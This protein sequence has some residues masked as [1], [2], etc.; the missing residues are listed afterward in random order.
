MPFLGSK[1]YISGQKLVCLISRTKWP[2]DLLNLSHGIKRE[3]KANLEFLLEL[4]EEKSGYPLN[5]R[6][7]VQRSFFIL[8]T[9]ILDDDHSLILLRQSR[10]RLQEATTTLWLRTWV[11]ARA[12]VPW[13]A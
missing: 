6:S 2:Y 5:Q 7:T 10:Q 13:S 9:T 12:P 11:A 8:K 4:I 3:T 1:V